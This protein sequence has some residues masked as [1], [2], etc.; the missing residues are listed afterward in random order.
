MKNKNIF[1]RKDLKS[2]RTS[3]R[4]RSTSAEV[5]LWEMLKSNQPPRPLSAFAILWLNC[6]A[7]TP[8]SKGGENIIK[9][10]YLSI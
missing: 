6:G 7:A 9:E 8:P 2:F 5:A 4:N 1:N 10:L 3:L